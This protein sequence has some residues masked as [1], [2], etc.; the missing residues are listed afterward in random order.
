MMIKNDVKKTMRNIPLTM[1]TIT[2][3]T[4]KQTLVEMGKF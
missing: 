1:L 2:D 3:K 4:V